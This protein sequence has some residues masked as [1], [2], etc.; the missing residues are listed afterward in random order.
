[1]EAQGGAVV[2]SSGYEADATDLEEAIRRMIGYELLTRGER[3]ALEQREDLL[4]RGRRLEPADAAVA[5]RVAYSILGPEG[6]PLPPIVDFDVLFIP[7]S[8]DKVVLIAP[9][10]TFHHVVDVRLLGP[11]GWNHPDLVSIGRNHVSGAVISALFHEQ[12]RFP[13]VVS[14]VDDYT[15]T[16]GEAPGVFAAHAYDAANLVLV[17]LARGRDTREQ[18]RDGIL[19][20]QGYPGASGVISIMPDGNARKRPFLLGVRGGRMIPLD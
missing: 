10:L 15:T 13:F 14:F 4:R 8:H 11:N 9:Q 12:S 16:F 2:A 17:Q 7:D 1:V 5:R 6:Q 3:A 19:R 20:T 18:V